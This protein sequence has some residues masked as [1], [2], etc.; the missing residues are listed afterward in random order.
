MLLEQTITSFLDDLA[1]DAPAP[2]GG[3][4][5]A[6]SGAMGAAL[7]SMVCRLTIGKKKYADVESEMKA[8]LERSEE[9][10]K[11]L[12]QYAEEDAEAFGTVGKAYGMPKK[13]EEE[14]AARSKAIQEALKVAEAAPMKTAEACAE[15]LELSALIAEKG[16]K[17]VISDSGS[18]A[19]LAI[20]GLMSAAYNAKVNLNWIKDEEFVKRESEKL[21]K[22]LDKGIKAKEKALAFV[23]ERM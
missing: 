1:S 19:M 18:A 10:R 23:D 2:G 5:A 17:N 8:A 20:G 22:I 3:A 21:Q 12:M 7:V 6:L 4:A 14:K 13:T 15:V 16:N 11:K 9:L